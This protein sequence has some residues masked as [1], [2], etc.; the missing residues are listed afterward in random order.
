MNIQATHYRGLLS[1]ARI[2][3]FSVLY[4]RILDN[5]ITLSIKLLIE[6]SQVSYG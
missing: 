4:I 2:C 3:I 6:S 1:K 5:I